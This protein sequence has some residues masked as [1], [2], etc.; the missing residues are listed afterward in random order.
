LPGGG[1]G[2][3]PTLAANIEYDNTSS[4]LPANN[5]QGAIDA[6]V[7]RLNTHTHSL[8]SLSDVSVS[9]TVPTG[10]AL[11][12]NGS[13]WVPSG[14]SGGGGGYLSNLY[15]V[16]ISSPQAGDALTYDGTKWTSR[17]PEKLKYLTVSSSPYNLSPSN[18]YGT[19]I[20][21]MGQTTDMLVT[22]PYAEE[23]MSVMFALGQS[24]SKR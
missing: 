11:V 8:A 16:D 21:N 20:N 9:G 12:W 13:V 4:A 1:G 3:A 15:D 14:V 22:L 2:S 17:N 5:V 18:S 7:T 10:Y 19:I 24:V 23:G 6:V